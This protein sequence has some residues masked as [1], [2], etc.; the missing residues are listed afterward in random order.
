M[1]AIIRDAASGRWRIFEDPLEVVLAN[2]LD[3][4]VPALERIEAECT[5]GHRYAAGFLSYEAA[6]AFDR[7]LTVA[8]SDGFPLL[9][10]GIYTRV[11]DRTLEELGPAPE[12]LPD[13][14]WEPSISRDEYARVFGD[15]QELIRAGDTYQVNY[16]YRLRTQLRINPF[17]LF[18][19]L[20]HTQ[21]PPFGA[22]ID[23]GDWLICSASPEL[24]FH[25]AGN[26]IESRPM[27]GTA[28]RGLWFEQ[29][30]ENAR[31]LRESDKE[32]SENVMIVDMVRNDL[33]RVARP[34][35][36]QVTNLFDVERYP[37]VLQLTSTV[38][39]ETASSLVD[40]MR[41]LF[42]AAS[43]TGAPKARTME[44]I[45]AIESSPRRIY[46]G[47]IGFVEPHGRSQ[48][49]VA[50]RTALVNALTGQAEYGVGGG[51]VADSDLADEWKE[52]QIKAR[53]LSGATPSFDLLE[54]LLWTPEAGYLLIGRHLKRL[55]Q[56]ADYFGFA[57]D[58]LDVRHQL[59]RYAEELP[60]SPHRVRLT[61]SRSGAAAISSRPHD[62][63]AGFPP[64][65]LAASPVDSSNRFLYHKTTNRKV[66]EDAVAACAGFEDVLLY[67]ERGEVTESTIANL[68]IETDGMLVTPP[69]SCG[70]LPGTLRAHLLEEG[71]IREK[72][73]T[74]QE[75]IDASGCYLVNSVR[76]FQPV[77]I[78]YKSVG[79]CPTS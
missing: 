4:V 72:V 50:I 33:G 48:F 70:L 52:S 11:D 67:N 6:P 73:I 14:S 53:P 56:S 25:R 36:V 64:I 63:G 34:G 54:T 45:A 10:F 44:I 27:K 16:T 66:Y 30:L 68:V 31:R 57:A 1:K 26:R 29:D 9:C 51:V 13:E 74:I 23:T 7:G 69:I 42:P 21:R 18:L 49:N 24:F 75:I 77:S 79:P 60:R 65:A 2:R 20:A 22:Y 39:A 28:A 58:L 5:R 38:A 19:H 55:L 3:D 32:R 71:K 17:T 59:D 8:G 76:G 61:V 37:T 35:T 40:V 12:M 46:T 41:A 43:I 78:D 47:T 62:I 15:L